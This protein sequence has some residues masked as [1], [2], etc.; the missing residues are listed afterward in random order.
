MHIGGVQKALLNL[1][2]ILGE[3]YDITLLL[4]YCGGELLAELPE[5]IKVISAAKSFQYWGMTKS[6][7]ATFTD[8]LL[9]AFWAGVTRMFGRSFSMW[10][11]SMLQK[12]I[13]GFDVAISFLHSGP[14]HMF[15]GGCNEFV[16]N[17][18][19]APKKFTFLH[20]DYGE[21][22]AVSK[23]N[24]G[25]YRRFDGIAACSDGCKK[26]FL[27]IFPQFS[28][29]T[30]I[31]PNF[32][33]YEAI[34]KMSQAQPVS[35]K[36]DCLNVLTVAR[37]GREKGILRALCAVADLGQQLSG[38]RYYIIGDGLEYTEA[39]K[40]ILKLGLTDTV[41][42]LGAMDNPYGYMK[43][44]DV[45]LIPSLSEAAPMVICEAA[46]LGTPVLTTATSSAIEM[47]Q[48]TGFGWVCPNTQGGIT[49][50][51]RRLLDA[52]QRLQEAQETLY[53]A[54]FDNTEARCR[55]SELINEYEKVDGA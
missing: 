51:I 42:L 20:C 44:A 45:L 11:A 14:L 25:I 6:D 46:F 7:V 9:R 13:R 5:G 49:Q 35:L 55:F 40:S 32:Q 19:D 26:T 28:E 47:V 23:Y 21:F 43:A 15:Y 24:E 10:V 27:N 48:D 12:R 41:F 33:N 39:K 31:V 1:L 50:G 2:Q 34:H 16:L 8:R 29:K 18:V 22:K 3:D 4:F 36:S 52:P 38:I 54:V 17:C 53:A 30:V 37:F